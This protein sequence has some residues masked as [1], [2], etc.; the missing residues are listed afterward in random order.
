MSWGILAE[1][2]RSELGEAFFTRPQETL[3]FTL[4]LWKEVAPDRF[5]DPLVLSE[6]G[7][8][9]TDFGVA[10]REFLWKVLDERS[11]RAAVLLWLT[12]TEW[13]V[14]WELSQSG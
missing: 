3:A 11:D 12:L 9:L 13:L 2:V 5:H 10:A 1:R 4:N 7:P 6:E 14:G 8:G